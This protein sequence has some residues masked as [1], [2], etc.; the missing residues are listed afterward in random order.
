M[1]T[2]FG[3]TPISLNQPVASSSY[4]KGNS[5][6]D[7]NDGDLATRWAA[8]SA[9]YPQ[10]WAVDLGSPQSITHAVINWY[11]SGSRA[12]PYQIQISNDGTNYT[13]LADHTG[14]STFGGTT[15][16]FLASARYVRI[17]VTGC[18]DPS[19]CASFYECKIYGALSLAPETPDANTLFLFHFDESAGS[20]VTTN[21]GI[22]GGKAYSVSESVASTTPPEVTDVLGATS[23][24]GFGNAATFAPG[25]LIGYDNNGSG[26]Y[27]GD[28]GPGQLSADSLYMSDLNMGNGGQ[29]PWTIEALICPS[30]IDT[31]NQE[32]VSTDSSP[33]SPGNRAFQFRIDYAGDL[34]LNL[35]AING[36]DIITPI[37][38]T[39]TDPVNGFMPNNWYHVA[40]TCDGTNVVLYWTKLSPS[41]TAANPISTNAVA[42][43]SAFG[44]VQGPLIIGN[45]NR[46]T[47]GEYFQG[48]IDEVRISNVARSPADMLNFDGGVTAPVAG[49]TNTGYA[50]PSTRTNDTGSYFLMASNNPPGLGSQTASSTPATSTVLDGSPPAAT[51]SD[52]FC[53]LLEQPEETVIT[54][55]NPKFGWVCHPSFRDDWQTGY[56]IIV[57][58]SAALADTGT[59]DMWDSG[60]VS[61]SNS[62]NVPY[63]GAALQPG[64][65]YY[66][67][68]QTVD[69]TGH[70]GAFSGI[71]QFNMASQLSDPLTTPGVVYQQPGAGSA[72][73]YPLRYVSIPPVLVTK[74]AP[75]V[76]LVDFG[77]D[78]FGFATVH[79]NGNYSGTTVNFGLGEAA[80]GN[81]V[82]PSPGATIRYRSGSIAL[83]NGDFIY[84]NRSSTS[85]GGISPP[86]GTYGIVSPFRYLELT[87]VPNNVTLTTNDVTQQRLQT[88]FDDHTATFDSSSTALNRVWSLC[89]Y[90]MEA[91]SFDGIYVD[92]DRERTPYEADTYIHQ[93]SSYGVNND[94]T[95]ARCSFE[96]LTNHLNWPT[97]WPMHMV[98]VAWADYQQT[99]DPYLIAKYYG[100]LTNR[101]LLSGRANPING[102]VQSY[103]VTG[104]T[105]SGDI[106]DWYRISG[107]GIGNTDGYVAEATNAVINA[108]YYRCLT[109]MTQ[110]AQVTG[111]SAD[112]ANF[113]ARAGLLYTSY[114][115]VFWNAL[116]QSYNDGP[117]TS[118]SSADANFFPLAFGLVPANRQAAVVNY[119]HSRMA[120]LGAMPA[121][122]YGAQYLLQ[123]LFEAGDADTALGLMTTNNTRSWMNMINIGSTL[124]DEAWSTADKSN[125]DW[126]H[127]WGAA[128]GNLIPRY[129]LGVRPL[130]AGYGRILIQPQLGQTLSFVQGAV[131]TIRGPVSVEATN[132]AGDF[133]LLLNIPGN[134][135]ATVILPATNS[136]ATLDGTIVSGSLSNDWLTLT[137]IGSGQHSIS[138][139]V[140]YPTNL[141][142]SLS[143][144]TLSLGWPSSYLGWYVQSNAISLADSNHWYGISGSQNSTSLNVILDPARPQVFYRLKSQNP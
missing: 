8:A 70:A 74:T 38:T 97:E 31:T 79:I 73:C 43:G 144:N 50:I 7:A 52:M 101:C 30:A 67:R 61:S 118:H 56:R 117:G 93:L 140:L 108:F 99:G 138:A 111:H 100:F 129:V 39:A 124:T 46:N 83:Q 44:L 133:Q 36:A 72:N 89:K 47:A 126:N 120:V 119:I 87:G 63:G 58:S 71:Q 103:P 141:T 95:M 134:V 96:Y 98:F 139:K 5:P 132:L 78:A 18:S 69:G 29:T 82:N 37:P 109:I 4:E 12:Y 137:N 127:A 136:A 60:L 62:I 94:F 86:T 32:I 88:E 6:T 13:V 41:T 121:G 51:N 68:V 122:V 135:T 24:T 14:N 142:F 11:N 123:G 107:D 92:G 112:A 105:A 131:P 66:W 125:E 102:L 84:T 10:W 53:D 26:A 115:N 65:S 59:G 28:A 19:G 110:I 15:D 116:S 16:N 106:I 75:G 49:A 77:K 1:Q 27:D 40:A 85:V 143:G 48:L 91:L 54:D 3:Q 130:T 114:N 90:S 113:A 57:S 42:V 9:A 104:N 81:S 22:L 80:N 34:E 2:G 23:Y 76:W 21:V 25:E 17:Y 55:P 35:I 20:S 64:G 128:P 33:N 45:E